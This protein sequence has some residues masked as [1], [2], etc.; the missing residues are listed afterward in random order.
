MSKRSALPR[1]ARDFYSTPIRATLPLLQFMDWGNP[2]KFI[3]PC[4]ADGKLIRHLESQ[5]AMKCVY[6]S[7]IQP[8]PTVSNVNTP[9][10][11]HGFKVDWHA[12][13]EALP[14]KATHFITNPP[15]LNTKESGFQLLDLIDTLSAVLPTILLLPTDFAFNVR[16]A[17]VIRYAT[18]IIPIGRVKWVDDSK[19]SSTENFGWFIF[20]QNNSKGVGPRVLPRRQKDIGNED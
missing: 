9:V 3:E 16:S 11:E 19:F 4:A 17:E 6:A 12:I 13:N 7:D 8:L 15:F 5:S 14:I 10:H 20:D 2:V 18:D 1:N